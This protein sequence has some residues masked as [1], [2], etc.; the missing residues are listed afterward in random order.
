MQLVYGVLGA[1]AFVINTDLVK[2]PPTSLKNC[3]RATTK[4]GRYRRRSAPGKRCLFAVYKCRPRQQCSASD[5][6]P[7]STISRIK[8]ERQFYR[9]SFERAN[10]TKGEVAL[11]SCGITWSRLPRSA[12][13]KPNLKVVIPS[14]GSIIVPMSRFVNKTAPHPMQPACD[15]IYFSDEGQLFYLTVMLTRLVT[16]NW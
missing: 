7:A 2:T 1:Q 4:H 11:P 14:D 3:W 8:K 6:Q 9:S 16:K 5:I 10:I 15:G 12:Q 13:G